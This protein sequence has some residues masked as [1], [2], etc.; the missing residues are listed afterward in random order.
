M[1]GTVE[2]V[3]QTT[4]VAVPADTRPVQ[5]APE[6]AQPQQESPPVPEDTGKTLDLY[7]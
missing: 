4:P 2:S 6:A 7:V 3:A 5:D 1:D